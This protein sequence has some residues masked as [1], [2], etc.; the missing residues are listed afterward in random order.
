MFELEFQDTEFS[1]VLQPNIFAAPSR[2][3][4]LQPREPIRSQPPSLFTPKP[5]EPS[6]TGGFTFSLNRPLKTTEVPNVFASDLNRNALEQE[7]RKHQEKVQEE[8]ERKRQEEIR[9]RN[10]EA[11]EKRKLEM[12]RLRRQEEEMRR[13]EEEERL[14]RERLLEEERRRKD[15]EMRRKLAEM[16]KRRREAEEER[17]KQEIKDT[18][19]DVVNQM[20]ERV[21]T[22]LREEALRRIREK[23]K[24]RMLLRLCRK[25]RWT[26]ANRVKKRKALDCKPIFVHTRTLAECAQDFHAK[27]ES[28]TLS[29]I[30]RYVRVNNVAKNY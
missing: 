25:W 17:K 4:R 20:V 23:I 26:T 5:P 28:L 19:Y 10:E 16:E 6:K 29:D 21:V 24:Q 22:N 3:P 13:K 1:D 14:R 2:D 7:K 27:S 30:K 11:A 15:E 12:E 9:R 18:V 8:E